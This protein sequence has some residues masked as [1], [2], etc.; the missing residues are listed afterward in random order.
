MESA[1]HFTQAAPNKWD[2]HTTIIRGYV[3]LS[4]D[5]W[6]WTAFVGSP[7]REWC[8]CFCVPVSRQDI[9]TAGGPERY[10]KVAY[11]ALRVSHAIHVTWEVCRRSYLCVFPLGCIG[12]SH[13]HFSILYR[14]VFCT[15]CYRT[16]FPFKFTQLQLLTSVVTFCTH[17]DCI[18]WCLS[19]KCPHLTCNCSF[20]INVCMLSFCKAS[21]VMY[22]CNNIKS[23]LL[24]FV[25]LSC[26]SLLLSLVIFA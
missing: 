22:F 15:N 4:Q 3:R 12:I 8:V 19:Q 13:G 2:C 23:H 9:E 18:L 10:V 16:L 14:C 25:G 17:N 5:D 11:A 21:F 24:A 7:G 1:L 26:C 20:P 6:Q